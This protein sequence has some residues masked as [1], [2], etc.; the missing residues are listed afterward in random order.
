[1]SKKHETLMAKLMANSVGDTWEE[2]QLEWVVT[3]MW[4]EEGGSCDCGHTPITD[5]LEIHNRLTDT[6]LVVGNVCVKK[7]FSWDDYDKIFKGIKK[8]RKDPTA[9]TPGILL[10]VPLINRALDEYKLEFLYGRR[11]TRRLTE[12]QNAFRLKCHKLILD[13]W[14]SHRP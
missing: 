3:G 5:H 13:T 6:T 11:F 12:K 10:E 7:F 2:A 14:D 1:M 8:L 4:E 9:G